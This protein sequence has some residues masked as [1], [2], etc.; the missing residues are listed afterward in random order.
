MA[1][2]F[3]RAT[4]PESAQVEL[5]E[6][7]L[8][9][10]SR[11]RSSRFCGHFWLKHAGAYRN[12]LWAV[13]YTVLGGCSDDC[14]ADFRTWLVGCGRDRYERA[15][16]QPDSLC[17]AFR[18]IPAG[19][20][21]L[22]EWFLHVPFDRRFGEGSCDQAYAAFGFGLE[23]LLDPEHAWSH[24]DEGSISVLCP[25]VFSEFWGNGRF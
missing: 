9:E 22:L 13:A 7:G 20:I 6:A 16:R 11:R 2:P 25:G 17:E 4:G 21:P 19:E 14:F 23:Q 3:Q 5:L 18:E 1:R 12:D 10:L 15:P 8:D 24:E